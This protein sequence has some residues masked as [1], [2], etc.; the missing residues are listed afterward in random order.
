MRNA[1]SFNLFQIVK[2]DTSHMW[3]EILDL[4][5]SYS[6]AVALKHEN[7]RKQLATLEHRHTH[8]AQLLSK[9]A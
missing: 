1:A 7:T 2:A 3:S 9:Q 6:R 5:K 4:C 8:T